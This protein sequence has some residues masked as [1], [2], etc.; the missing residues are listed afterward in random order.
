M[1]LSLTTADEYELVLELA[2]PG[3][4]FAPCQPMTM[5]RAH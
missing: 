5:K 1:H 3:Q 4:D 2:P